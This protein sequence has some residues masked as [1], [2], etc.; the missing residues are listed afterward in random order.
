MFPSLRAASAT[1]L[2][3]AAILLGQ[4]QPRHKLPAYKNGWTD[5]AP[6]IETHWHQGEPYNLLTPLQGG[7]HSLAGCIAIAGAQVAYHF[8]RDNPNAL[9]HTTPVY[10][11]VTLS[12]PAGTP[13]EWELMPLEG[14]GTAEQNQAVATLVYA[15]ATTAG[16]TFGN[17]ST[18]GYDERMAYA[19]NRQMR[20]LCS[21]RQKAAYT[22]RAWEELIYANL[23]SGRPMLCSGLSQTGS[24]HTAVIDGYQASTGLYHFNFGWGGQGDGWYTVDDETGIGGYSSMQTLVC[25]ITPQI[26]NLDGRLGHIVLC[27]KKPATITAT[28]TNNGTLHY[29]GFHL[30]INTEPHLPLQPSA[31]DQITTVTPGETTTLDFPLTPTTQGTAYIFLCDKN[32]RILDSCQVCIETA[33]PHLTSAPEKPGIRYN[34]LGQRILRSSPR[35]IYIDNRRKRLAPP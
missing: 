17:N 15:L 27:E 26:Q 32:R 31:I 4:A 18:N 29:T 8:R 35:T 30:Y 24:G 22:Q 13:L 19:L 7:Q 1:L 25:D 6:L 12:L 23:S 28:I 16:L 3:F 20:L 5:I 14:S 34:L 9:L 11:G 10:D 21:F 2:L 33:L